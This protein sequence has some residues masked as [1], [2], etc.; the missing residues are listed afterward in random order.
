MLVVGDIGGTKT[1]LA[2][3]APSSDPRAPLAEKEYHSASYPGLDTIVRTFLAETGQTAEFGCFDVAGPVV[4]GQAHVTNLPWTMD[5]Q[6]LA[7][8]I[9]L[10]RVMLLNDLKAIATA[11]PSLQAT[12]LHTLNQGRAEPGGAIAVIAPGTGL[13]EAF[14]VWD[15]ARYIAC[16]SEGGHASFAPANARQVELWRHMSERF[17]A[18]SCERVCSGLGIGNI[19][20]FLRDT[21]AFAESPAFA[22]GMHQAADRTPLISGAGL[23]NPADNPLAAATMELFVEILAGEAGNLALKVMSTGGVYLAG[24]IPTHILPRL[25]DGR[26]L[27][28]FA[29]KGRLAGI[30]QRMPVHVATARAALIGAARHGLDCFSAG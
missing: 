16:A 18:V 20:D 23:Q 22:Q 13:G 27:R 6:E 29:D 21:A 8:D 5:E 4:H 2:L 11:V 17:G 19:Y 1:L 24:G 10:K 30:L 3:F 25:G 12:D 28:A 15:G 14:L 9:G 7:H 26:F